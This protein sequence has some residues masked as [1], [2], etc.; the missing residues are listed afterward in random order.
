[1]W[2]SLRPKNANRKP[3]IIINTPVTM[4]DAL[5]KGFVIDI[6]PFPLFGALI[7]VSAANT[8]CRMA[9]K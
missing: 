9:K 6:A 8:S 2:N 3:R 1:M 5:E 7:I 4:M